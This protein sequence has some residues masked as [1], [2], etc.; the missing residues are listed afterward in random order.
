[1]DNNFNEETLNSIAANS[2]MN[3]T[4]LDVNIINE[5]TVNTYIYIFLY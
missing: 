3:F 5:V 4:T 2:E 1:V